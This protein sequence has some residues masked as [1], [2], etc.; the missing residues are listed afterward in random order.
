MKFRFEYLI[1]FLCVSCSPVSKQNLTRTFRGAEQKFQ[2]H[3]GFVL[4]DISKKETVYSYNGEKYFTPASNTKI[5]TLYTALQ[6]LGDSIPGLF[7]IKQ[8]DSLIF[9]GTGDPSFLYERVAKSNK[10]FNFLKQSAGD[11]YFSGSNFNTTALGSGWAWSDYNYAFSSERSS[12][13][14][15]GNTFTVTQPSTSVIHVTPAYFKKYFWLADSTIKIANVVREIGSNRTDYIPAKVTS[16]GKRWT[17]PY[18]SDPF[19]ISNLLEDTLKRK[20]NV[21]VK[22]L[23][24]DKSILYSVSAD[25]L[26][27]V[28][29]QESDNFLAEQLLLV[30][31]GVLSDTLKPEIAIRFMKKNQL[32]DLP[33]APVWVDGSGLSRYNLFTPR[34]IVNLWEK[35]YNSVE[36]ERLFHLL[37][38]GG[39]AGTIKDQYQNDPPYIYGKTGTL[40][41]NHSLSGY[42]I[43]KKGKTLIFSFMNA[44]YTVPVREVR[45]EMEKILKLIYYNY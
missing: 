31:A 10:V 1:A 13:P 20:V 4:Y 30:C 39:K 29:M 23:P 9:W 27:K 41:N 22:Q 32:F 5:F 8:N 21:L 43:T 16:E 3:T 14:L 7:Y 37:A 28:M 15:Y 44:N 26:Y 17:V 18:K 19:L 38:V 11:L 12:F 45:A 6:I 2:D 36:R 34:T 42:L 40:S 25:S 33:D 24:I 35:M